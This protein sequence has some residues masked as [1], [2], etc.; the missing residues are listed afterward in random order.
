MLLCS[1]FLF[2]DMYPTR[3]KWTYSKE[4]E[5]KLRIYLSPPPLPAAVLLIFRLGASP[6]S[7]AT[8]TAK[9]PHHLSPRWNKRHDIS[10]FGVHLCRMSLSEAAG[11]LSFVF[12]GMGF[13]ETELLPLRVYAAAGDLLHVEDECART[14]A[15]DGIAEPSLGV[16]SHHFFCFRATESPFGPLAHCRRC[17]SCC[18]PPL[19]E[20]KS[21]NQRKDM[22][23]PT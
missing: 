18:Q 3:K 15:A 11:H 7:I 23:I 4:N 22:Y 2:S 6:R 1:T 13:L 9:L 21:R 12:L 17:Y 16:E 5:H 10:L 19:A 14:V 20:R 8:H